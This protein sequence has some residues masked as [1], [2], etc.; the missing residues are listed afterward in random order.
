MVRKGFVRIVEL[1][2]AITLV[3]IILLLVYK[4]NLPT[5]NTQDL[6]E[7]A[8][9][10]LTEVSSREDLRNEIVLQQTSSANMVNTLAFIDSL[11]PDYINF[12]LRSCTISSACGQ[13]SYVGDVYSAERIIS[14]S[15]TDFGPIKLRL[16]LW[17]K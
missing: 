15:S 1:L 13:S 8:R 11:V 12:E 10:I 2:I 14:T 16:F 6:A 4:Q 17:Q 7:L 5:Q 3:S 9:D